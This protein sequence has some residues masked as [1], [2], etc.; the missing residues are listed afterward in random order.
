MVFQKTSSL[1][2][3]SQTTP[4]RTGGTTTRIQGP[5]I[6]SL[7]PTATQ[8]KV[9]LMAQPKTPSTPT[10]GTPTMFASGPN[11]PTQVPST[12]TIIKMVSQNN[13]VTGTGSSAPGQKIVMVS[14]PGTSASGVAAAGQDV[15][16]KSVFTTSASG[17][18][19]QP[20]I[21]TLDGPPTEPK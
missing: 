21:I 3:G 1:L 12:P 13:T 18:P 14:V 11:T 4:L 15:G 8:Q 10:V 2:S 5:N 17:L 7:T 9:V 16:I 20:E 6:V 19:Q